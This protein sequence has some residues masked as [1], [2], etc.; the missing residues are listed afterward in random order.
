MSHR[1][2]A[3]QSARRMNH[4]GCPDFEYIRTKVSVLT[5][6][7]ELGLLVN[8]CRARC[9]RPERHRNGDADP[10]V[11][12]H[13]AM[14][15]GR[16]FVCDPYPWSSIDLVMS[17]R[18]C[19]LRD[20]VSWITDRFPVPP[21]AKGAHLEAREAWSP[22][23]RASDTESVLEMLVRSCLWGTLSHAERSI[24][25]VLATFARVNNGVAEISYRG[26]MRYSGVGSHATIAKSLKHFEQMRLLKVVRASA[27]R[28][29]R[30]VSQYSFSFDDPEFQAMVTQ[31]FQRQREEM[32]LEKALREEQRAGRSKPPLPV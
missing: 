32:E 27:A 24:L 23:F 31:V 1:G 28:P 7:R 4:A 8:G 16:C 13:K 15:K 5:V 21:V 30:Q 25:P 11:R 20:A 2:S 18:A 12:F 14:N 29:I 10:S 6:A 17:V 22:R 26:L 3:A 9:W 19:N